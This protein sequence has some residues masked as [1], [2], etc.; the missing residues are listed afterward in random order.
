VLKNGQLGCVGAYNNYR[1]ADV[2]DQRDS[3]F[4]HTA[5]GIDWKIS[6]P[7]RELD[8]GGVGKNPCSQRGKGLFLCDGAALLCSLCGC[9]RDDECERVS[10]GAES[11]QN[12]E[13]I[14]KSG[15]EK[16]GEMACYLEANVINPT[17]AC[18]FEAAA[19]V[20]AADPLSAPRPRY[21]PIYLCARAP[22]SARTQI[23]Q[24]LIPRERRRR[25]RCGPNYI[26]KLHKHSRTE[27]PA[28]CL[29]SIAY[30]TK[31]YPSLAPQNSFTDGQKRFVGRSWN[32]FI[33]A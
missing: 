13:W 12:E 2:R 5:R 16:S 27:R 24:N 15:G 33:G 23:N 29:G 20:A 32:T 31:T 18:P 10:E 9:W 25:G 21:A 14:K 1:S 8:G 30:Y 22:S 7:R 6:L 28:R 19:A 11:Y 26:N 17:L 4:F 3:V